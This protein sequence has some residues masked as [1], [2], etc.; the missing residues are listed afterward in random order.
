MLRFVYPAFLAVISVAI[1]I[2]GGS[3]QAGY[4]LGQ[5]LIVFAVGKLASWGLTGEGASGSRSAA[6]VLAVLAAAFVGLSVLVSAFQRGTGLVPIAFGIVFSVIAVRRQLTGGARPYPGTRSDGDR[7]ERRERNGRRPTMARTD[8]ATDAATTTAA[9]S[10]QDGSNVAEQHDRADDG[11]R[12]AAIEWPED[13]G[14]NLRL[15]LTALVNPVAWIAFLVRHLLA[16]AAQNGPSWRVQANARTCPHCGGALYRPT[17]LKRLLE[18]DRLI[19]SGCAR[20]WIPEK[21]DG[22]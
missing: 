7:D 6:H 21:T 12:G 19:C 17:G 18:G 2:V 9:R 3:Y 5:G 1:G 16:G 15:L 4:V 20:S 14:G 10:G 11:G 22:T 8:G 13:P